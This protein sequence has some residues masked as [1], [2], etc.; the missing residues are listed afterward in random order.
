MPSRR[1]PNSSF[2][3]GRIYE[4]PAHTRRRSEHQTAIMLLSLAIL[5]IIIVLLIGG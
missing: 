1:L 3:Y 2:K 4:V 5:G